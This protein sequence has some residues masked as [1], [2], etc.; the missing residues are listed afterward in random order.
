M[1]EYLSVAEKIADLEGRTTRR[2]FAKMTS[3]EGAGDS[4]KTVALSSGKEARKSGRARNTVDYTRVSLPENNHHE[5]A[6]PEQIEEGRMSPVQRA[7][8]TSPSASVPSTSNRSTLLPDN[9]SRSTSTSTATNTEQPERPNRSWNA[10]VY[11]ILATSDGPLTFPQLVQSIKNRYPFFN[12]SSQD[13]VLKSGPKNPLYFHEA[14]CRAEIVNGKQSWALK[15]G[16]FVDKKTGEVL[17]PQ[18]RYTISS[19]RNAQQ[20]QTAEDR[21]PRDST[22]KSSH[23]FN[24]SSSIPRFGRE[25]LNSPEIPDSQDARVITPS[26]QETDSRIATEQPPHLER[27]YQ[28]TPPT[29]RSLAYEVNNAADSAFT[30][31][32]NGAS[33]SGRSPQPQL[34]WATTNGSPTS[35]TP[36]GQPPVAA[37]AKLQSILQLVDTVDY[38]TSGTGPPSPTAFQALQPFG[39]SISSSPSIVSSTGEIGNGS[40]SIITQPASTSIPPVHAV[41]PTSPTHVTTSLESRAATSQ[42]PAFTPAAATPSVTTLP[43]MQL[44]V[45]LLIF[46]STIFACFSLTLTNCAHSDGTLKDGKDGSEETHNPTCNVGSQVSVVLPSLVL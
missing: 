29:V 31:V 7:N 45:V 19:P 9:P 22:S 2:A 32:S 3:G 18:P 37:G 39:S 34:Q 4:G 28:H 35:T 12:S 40:N 42:L 30:A 1:P 41:S 11:E 17:T 25:I 6:T 46:I 8:E 5:I 21:T 16:V 38:K 15:P 26:P 23:S 24:P 10:I 27:A 36:Y 44:Y 20:I 14:F 33:P 43:S 13:K